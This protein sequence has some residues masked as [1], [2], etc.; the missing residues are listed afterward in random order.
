MELKII[1]SL[2]RLKYFDKDLW[3][4]IFKSITANKINANK[5][6]RQI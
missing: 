6:T 4:T 1:E 5:M 2:I 3:E